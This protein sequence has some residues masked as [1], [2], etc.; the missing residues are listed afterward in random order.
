MGILG[1]SDISWTICK[2]S[3]PHSRHITTPAPHH[4]VFYRPDALPATQP[5]ASEHWRQSIQA[6]SFLCT[7]FERSWASVLC[8]S[9]YVKHCIYMCCVLWFRTIHG[10][11]YNALKLFMEMNQKLFDSCTQRFKLEVQKWV[12]MSR[13]YVIVSNVWFS[14]SVYCHQTASLSFVFHLKT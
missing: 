6:H 13:Q 5:A 10:L 3:A 11:I 7:L 4:S 9:V 2:Q 1:C 14:A 12:L 8:W